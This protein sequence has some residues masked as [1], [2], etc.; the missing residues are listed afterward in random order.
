[1]QQRCRW[2]PVPYDY[3]ICFHSKSI[4]S[5]RCCTWNV[6]G[7]GSIDIGIFYPALIGFVLYRVLFEQ[8]QYVFISLI[9]NKQTWL[10]LYLIFLLIPEITEYDL[11]HGFVHNKE[12]L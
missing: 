11:N 3:Q 1:M 4:S 12:K 6:S 7:T 9:R 10:D 2:V 8:N 5:I